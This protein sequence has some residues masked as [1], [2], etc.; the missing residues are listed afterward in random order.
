MLL[1]H[2][3]I[4]VRTNNP[5]YLNNKTMK[6]YL[7][8]YWKCGLPHKF[9]VRYANNVQSIRNIEMILATSYKLLIWNNGVIV[10]KWQCD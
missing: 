4:I 8:E 6:K 9:V 3:N 7:I 10:H 5:H 1:I 2:S